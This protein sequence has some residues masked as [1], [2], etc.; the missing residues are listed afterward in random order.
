[1]LRTALGVI[2]QYT[3][4][5]VLDF[6]QGVMPAGLTFTRNYPAWRTNASGLYEQVAANVARIDYDPVTRLCRGLLIEESRANLLFYS[7]QF[8]YNWSKDA[9]SSF[10]YNVSAAPD[11]SITATRFTPGATG[12][13][14]GTTATTANRIFQEYSGTNTA[15]ASSI[16]YKTDTVNT[17]VTIFVVNRGSD[18]PVAS[19]TAT[20][21]STWQRISV[22]GTTTG[23]NAG[24]RF[25]FASS[26]PVLIWN[27]QLEPGTFATSDIITTNVSITRAADVCSVST[28]GWMN[29]NE[30]TFVAEF[31]GGRAST[32]DYRG[33]VISSGTT[34]SAFL[35][36]G[37]GPTTVESWNGTTGIS[38]SNAVDYN[39]QFAKAAISYNEVTKRRAVYAQGPSGSLTTGSVGYTGSYSATSLLI[40]SRSGGGQFLNGHIKRIICYPRVLPNPF[41]NSL[42]LN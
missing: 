1:M 41:L 23:A 27:A 16:W 39:A 6:S 33:C 14:P 36:G 21:S 10:T 4:S 35:G 13:T 28:P 19:L 3:P 8:I 29:Q 26:Q 2:G 12:N 31:R 30:G 24:V 9:A 40:G 32:Q 22:S 20:S 42:I 17:T 15:Y 25:L 34:L 5:L 38:V 7:N 18:T 11:G 37:G